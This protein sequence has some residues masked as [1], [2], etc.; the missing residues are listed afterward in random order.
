MSEPVRIAVISESKAV[1]GAEESLLRICSRGQ[2]HGYSPMV[3]VG[4]NS[5]LLSR[6]EESGIPAIGHRFA[7]HVTLE[8]KGSL[9]KS[10]TRR[11]IQDF[12]SICRG[13]LRLLPI[14]RSCDAVLIFSLWQAPETILAAIL[15]RKPWILDLHETFSGRMAVPIV[16]RIVKLSRGTI[17]PSRF[18]LEKYGVNYTDNIAVVPRPIEISPVEDPET[19]HLSTDDVDVVIGIFGQIADHKQVLELA[20]VIDAGSTVRTRLLV[21]GGAPVGHRSDYEL[22]VR[23]FVM[24]M[25]CGSK[26]I[27]RVSEPRTLMSTCDFVINV[28]KH[29]A[30]GRGVVEA[31]AA[32]SIP[33]VLEDS[34]PAEIVRFTSI[35]V[36]VNSIDDI[37]KVLSAYVGGEL[38]FR[39]ELSKEESVLGTFEI[40]SI[41]DK[42]FAAIDGFLR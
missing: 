15:T 10:S 23:E 16:R 4:L 18:L 33:L 28:S 7:R 42:Y 39:N 36:V 20:R 35:G 41:T 34:G 17:S 27:D 26:V 5:P 38:D 12:F 2:H 3:V 32:K 19:P 8:T 1:W 11:L 25:K 9:S 31:I 24:E 22:E 37:P 30:F 21:V 14:I 13:A 40:S 29:E 6:L